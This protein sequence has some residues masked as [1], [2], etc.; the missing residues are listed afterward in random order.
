[1]TEESETDTTDE[2][3]IGRRCDNCGGIYLAV[4][5]RGPGGV[6]SLPCCGATVQVVPT[7]IER[8]AAERGAD[9]TREAEARA[10]GGTAQSTD[11]GTSESGTYQIEDYPM[12]AERYHGDRE[13]P[14]QKC[15]NTADWLVEAESG[16]AFFRCDRCSRQNRIYVRENELLRADVRASTIERVDSEIEEDLTENIGKSSTENHHASEEVSE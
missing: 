6:A 1:M 15:E 9:E 4:I 12:A 3:T 11:G 5:I 2:P 7:E 16:T 14:Y 8:S 10:D 13:C